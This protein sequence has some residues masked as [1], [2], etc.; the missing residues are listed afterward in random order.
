MINPALTITIGLSIAASS[1]PG[2]EVL[3]TDG[4]L[5]TILLAKIKYVTVSLVVY[6]RV[7]VQP[8]QKHHHCVKQYHSTIN[9]IK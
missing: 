3:A 8:S 2:G 7:N 1:P 4:Q 6:G 5:L 9:A